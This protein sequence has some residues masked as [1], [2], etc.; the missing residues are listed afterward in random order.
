MDPLSGARLTNDTRMSLKVWRKDGRNCIIAPSLKGGSCRY[1]VFGIIFPI[2][3]DWPKPL[4]DQ[5]IQS[6][7]LG[8]LKIK[9]SDAVYLVWVFNQESCWQ[10][11]LRIW[12]QKALSNV[13]LQLG[14]FQGIYL[15]IHLLP[16]LSHSEFSWM[17]LRILL[18]A[19]AIIGG[20]KW[21]MNPPYPPAGVPPG[22]I[23]Q[24]QSVTTKQRRIAL[25][26]EHH[27]WPVRETIGRCV[28]QCVCVEAHRSSQPWN[29]SR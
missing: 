7:E 4:L 28:S 20:W 2:T 1:W 9:L 3:G 12:R 15:L 29:V 11:F 18:H 27:S 5:W 22:W 24:L 16:A 19:N 21:V 23:S 26:V 13:H 6:Y 14:S 8:N 17:V 25:V 10:A